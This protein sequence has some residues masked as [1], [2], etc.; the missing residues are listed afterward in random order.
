MTTG[1]YA[2]LVTILAVASA[3]GLGALGVG[4]ARAIE[5]ALR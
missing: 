3:F 1:L 5:A 2:I 4:L